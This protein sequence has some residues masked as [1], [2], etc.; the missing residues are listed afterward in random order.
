MYANKQK[1]R[2]RVSFGALNNLKYGR[3]STFSR[4]KVKQSRS[5]KC[6]TAA[7]YLLNTYKM[8]LLRIVFLSI[9][10]KERHVPSRF[11][12]TLIINTN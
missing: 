8:V 6:L 5:D 3:G 2:V 11:Y 9:F 1:K 12:A 7:L 4:E 10:A